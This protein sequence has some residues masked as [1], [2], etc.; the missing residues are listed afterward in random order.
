VPTVLPALRAQLDELEDLLAPLD[1]AGWAKPTPCPGWSVGDVVLHL[2]QTNEMATASV[3]GTRAEAGRNWDRVEG[4]TVDDVAGAAVAQERGAAAAEIHRRWRASADEM[5][6]AFAA[7]P[8]DER[9][10]W[11]AGDMAAR[12]LATTRVAETWIH[13]EDVAA[14]LGVELAG[15]ARLRHIA[16]LV[17]RT[18]PYAFQREGEQPPGSVRFVLSAP[19]G[20]QQW[21]FGA[22]DAATTISG[23][24]LDLCRVAGQRAPATSTAL[25]GDGPDADRVLALMRTFA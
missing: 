6:G 13:T 8:A 25:T 7:C 10:M 12:T 14:G 9:V 4:A 18:L 19:G 21:A 3:Q 1:D 24:A 15:T 11:V 16:W 23:P 2:A 5:V 17:H 20:D 22:D